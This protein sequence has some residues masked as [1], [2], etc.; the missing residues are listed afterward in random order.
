MDKKIKP[1]FIGI[2]GGSGSGKSTLCNTLRKK[3]QDKIGLIQLDDYFKPTA[4]KPKVGNLVNSDHPDALFLDKLAND[5]IKL[6]EGKSVI[7][8]TKN[9]EL[10]PEYERTK[11]RIP[12]EFFPKPTM[13]VEGFLL[14][15]DE[16]IRELLDT[17]IFLDVNHGTRW[18]RRVHLENKNKEY[19]EK[20]I[21]PMHNQ[22]IEPT[23]K[24]ADYVID[25]SSL[26]KEQVLEKVEKI[27]GL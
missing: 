10:N 17:I 20:V 9:E 3:Y 27:L 1:I 21:I 19:E 18:A 24:Y 4:D 11:K 5:L 25:V 2:T 12:V 23:K 22:Y 6:G 26:N 16:K 7:I 13:L 15:H 8:N 14:L